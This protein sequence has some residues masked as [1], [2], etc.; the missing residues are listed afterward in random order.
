MA[1]YKR[2]YK[3]YDGEL[4]PDWSRFLIIPRHA[5][6]NIFRYRFMVILYVICFFYPIGCALTIYLNHNLSFLGA[7]VQVPKDGLLTIG[8]RF[9]YIFTNVQGVLAFILTAFIG[10]GL[11]SS[12]L[13][14]NALPLYFCRPLSRTEYVIGKICVIAI[15]LSLITWVPGLILFG[16]QASLA[17]SAWLSDNYWIAGSIV[18]SS[19]LWILLVSVLALALSA[20]VRWRIVAGGLMLVV[21]FMGAGLAQMIRLVLRTT[22]GYWVDPAT[23]IARVWLHLFRITDPQDFTVGQ[24]TIALL[25]FSSLCVW[26]LWKKV[27]AYEVVRG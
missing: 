4:T 14:N 7:Y 11:V 15:L 20:W 26:M 3:G 5:W 19:L 24:A 2:S 21:F 22:E 12:D 27:R 23:N 25:L 10:P 8:N 9:F 16:L 1:V 13:S 18:A 17:G 6:R